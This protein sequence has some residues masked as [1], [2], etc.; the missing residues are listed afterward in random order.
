MTEAY[1][2][3]PEGEPLIV[4]GSSGED[5]A[6]RVLAV[7]LETGTPLWQTD[8]P[9]TYASGPSRV[10]IASGLIVIATA[11][12]MVYC[13][14]HT[15]GE[16]MW[17]RQVWKRNESNKYEPLLMIERRRILVGHHG[18]L[19]CFASDGR[20]LWQQQ[21]AVSVLGLDGQVVEHH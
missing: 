16:A 21:F 7:D 18:M 12:A 1:R 4:V 13:I 14:H 20:A 5:G 17:S 19:T 11:D 15:T 3:P 8:V 6:K 2:S 10:A 9:T